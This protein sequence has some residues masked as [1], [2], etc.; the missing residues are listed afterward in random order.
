MITAGNRHNHLV[1]IG[2][3]VGGGIGIVIIEVGKTI[4]V[5][6]VILPHLDKGIHMIHPFAL[7]Q[8]TGRSPGPIGGITVVD[9]RT[10]EVVVVGGQQSTVITCAQL[11][12]ILLILSVLCRGPGLAHPGG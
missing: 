9:A 12:H 6:C 11:H 10:I 5:H 3:R 1:Q 7:G 4:V 8:N 2:R